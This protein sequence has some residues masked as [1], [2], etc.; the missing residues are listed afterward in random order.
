MI[1]IYIK[2]VDIVSVAILF[3][4][5]VSGIGFASDVGN[6]TVFFISIIVAVI[7]AFNL[8]LLAEFLSC[9]VDIRNSTVAFAK[10]FT[11]DQIIQ[12]IPLRVNKNNVK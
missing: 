11:D 8:Q 4:G 5:F 7:M 2:L 12:E 1:R 10:K 3:A 6:P 9:Y